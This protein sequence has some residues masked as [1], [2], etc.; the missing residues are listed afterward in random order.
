MSYDGSHKPD[1]IQRTVWHDLNA[2]GTFDR[3]TRINETFDQSRAEIL[4]DGQW[5][6]GIPAR[7]D[8]TSPCT[9]DVGTYVFDPV[10]INVTG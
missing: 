10:K 1:S 6:K 8:A 5:V 2:D 3:R 7:N 4:I 9:T